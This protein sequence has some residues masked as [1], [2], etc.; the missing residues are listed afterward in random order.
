M[1]QTAN[2]T[3]R[4]LRLL[5]VVQFLLLAGHTMAQNITVKGRVLK[6]DGQPVQKASVLVKGTSNGTTT[7][8][9]GDFTVSAPG[10][11]TLVISAVDFVSQDVKINNRTTLS[12]RLMAADKSLEGV[13]VVGYGTQRRRDVTGSVASVGEKALREVPVANLQQALQGRAAGLEVQRVG[14]KPGSGAV[15]RIRGERTING[16]ND[17]LIILDGIPFEGGS[18]ND[19]NPDDVASVDILKDASATAVYGS[20]GSNG[21]ILITTKKGKP[22]ESRL[23]Y[24]GYYGVTSVR[25]KYSV[26]NAQE[27]IAMRDMTNINPYMPEEITSRANGTETNWQDLMYQNGYVTDHNLT[28]SGGTA[29]GSTYSLGGGYYK[30]TTVLPGQDFS[31]YSLKATIDAKIG[32]RFKVGLNTMNTLGLTNGSQFNNP[33]FPFLP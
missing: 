7:D 1:K 8:D 19:I 30:E 26:L 11:G 27:Y 5:V 18:L 14:T 9:N 16:S 2:M 3:K 21:V 25:T 17:P 24:N 28:I 29:G 10:N 4:L 6:D 22:G 33:M 12:I 15:I 31:R 23:T 32:T 13:V 20:R